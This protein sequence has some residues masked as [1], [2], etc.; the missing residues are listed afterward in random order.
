MQEPN[1]K[2]AR[3]VSIVAAVFIALACG[4]NVSG[5]LE[6]TDSFSLLVK[7][8]LLDMGP[9]IRRAIEAVVHGEQ[10][11]RMPSRRLLQT[12]SHKPQGSFGNFGM[13]IP[14]IL[15]GIVVDSKGPRLGVAFG[16]VLLGIGYAAIYSG[17]SR[18][19]GLG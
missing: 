4:T 7:V 1:L 11:N 19:T 5:L 2:G 10:P 3:V 9:A 8:R 6:L 14:A 17:L 13:Y 15:V 16:A 18:R 12:T